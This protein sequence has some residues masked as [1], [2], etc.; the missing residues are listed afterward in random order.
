M[1]EI[2]NPA[3]ENLDLLGRLDLRSSF[4]KLNLWKQVQ[5]EKVVF[6]D[7]DT[8]V[9]Q[10][11]DHLFDLDVD[12]AAAPDI[13]WP[14]IFNSGVFFTK[15]S[16]ATY[17]ALRNLATA[18]LSFDGGDQGLLNSFYP[19]YK[20]LSFTYNVTPSAGYQYLPAYRHFETQVKV[21]H[22][23][24]VNKPW[25]PKQT[26]ATELTGP[27]AELLARWKAT[28]DR[29]YPN[30]A[31][32]EAQS[33]S[34]LRKRRSP[35]QSFLDAIRE[36][37]DHAS[38]SNSPPP[39]EAS[40]A[41]WDPQTSE[42]PL[43]SGP[44]AAD[45]QY[46]SYTNSWDDPKDSNTFVPPS[47]PK[48]P[49][50]VHFEPPKVADPSASIF[51]WEGR[52]VAQRAFPEDAIAPLREIIEIERNETPQSEISEADHQQAFADYQFTNA[53]DSIQEIKDYV[54]NIPGASTRPR[55]PSSVWGSGSNTP[56]EAE[57]PEGPTETPT[58]SIP[59]SQEGTKVDFLLQEPS[60]LPR[61]QDWNPAAQ[62]DE[63]ATR[64]Q[65][66]ASE[67]ASAR[68]A[69]A[70]PAASHAE[71]TKATDA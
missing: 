46:M 2:S 11:I 38:P 68:A 4:T 70:S 31:M 6:L 10:N 42:P 14:D 30:A 48:L 64:A 29:H 59:G 34:F 47:T 69:A 24:G 45:L 53:W 36:E 33:P 18:G 56:R 71:V 52:S 65:I 61:P 57:L 17:A 67:A 23:I 60:N 26:Q 27:Y 9:L 35:P 25:N 39:F 21:A 43:S 62:L 13:G 8:L 16:I 51:P 40:Q 22:F 7:A 20:R 32:Q 28:Y 44:E 66:L 49:K 41:A 12:F 3:T 55:A 15:P 58:T 19:S 5:Y 63:L 54:A 1:D 50:S 37:Q